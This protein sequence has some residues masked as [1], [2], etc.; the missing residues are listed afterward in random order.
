MTDMRMIW[1]RIGYG[2]WVYDMN[3]SRTYIWDFLRD[4][5][6]FRRRGRDIHPGVFRGSY[7][8]DGSAECWVSCGEGM[9]LV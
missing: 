7:W 4:G 9:R 8:E 6:S 5:L 3:W 1:D 2:V